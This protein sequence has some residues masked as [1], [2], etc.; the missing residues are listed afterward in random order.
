MK[1]SYR[2]Q[3]MN[4]NIRYENAAPIVPYFFTAG[5]TKRNARIDTGI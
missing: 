2:M 5:P 3:R 4:I 1:I